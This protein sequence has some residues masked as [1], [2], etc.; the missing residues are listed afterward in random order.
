MG[1]VCG[2]VRAEKE[3]QCLDPAK[4]PLRLEKYSAGRRKYFRRDLTKKAA[5][6]TESGGPRLDDEGKRSARPLSGGQA[7][8]WAW[9]LVQERGASPGLTLQA[10]VQ[11]QMASGQRYPGCP[12]QHQE[13]QIRVSI[14]E[15]RVSE[16]DS[17]PY[18]AKRKDHFDDVNTRK[19]TFQR[20]TG[21]FSSQ[22]AAS[23]SSIHCGTERS[24]EKG[25]FSEDPS[26]NDSGIQEKQN[27]ERSCLQ[28][29]HRF[30]FGKKRYHSLCDNMS[31][32]SKD[33]KEVSA[34]RSRVHRVNKD[35]RCAQLLEVLQLVLRR[36]SLYGHLCGSSWCISLGWIV[37]LFFVMH[38]LIMTLFSNPLHFC[39]YWKTWHVFWISVVNVSC[40]F[41]WNSLGKQ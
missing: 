6:D 16:K 31:F 15:E 21:G 8:P 26:K 36:C 11:P 40:F 33:T 12:S 17:T 19:R 37:I 24:L 2:C 34:A 29:A 25:G 18:H 13:T 9:G 41:Q 4:T 20:K 5:D 28:E 32:P 30:Q 38:S 7:A 3:E 39:Y 14:P 1:N 22:K 27:T 35:S 23:L 10:G